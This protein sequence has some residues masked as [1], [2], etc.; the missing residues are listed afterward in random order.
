VLIRECYHGRTPSELLY[1]LEW[2]EVL[3]C[4]NK[5]IG[6]LNKASEELKKANRTR[7]Q[8]GN[9]ETVPLDEWKDTGKPKSDYAKEMREKILR[10]EV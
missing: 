7:R 5:I 10:G 8:S 4:W 1:D 3:G 6:E 2:W 9:I